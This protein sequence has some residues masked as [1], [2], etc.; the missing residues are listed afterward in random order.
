M[1]V[2]AGPYTLAAGRTVEV[3]PGFAQH[4]R[5]KAIVLTNLSGFVCAVTLQ[6]G[7]GVWLKPWSIHAY[8]LTDTE[9]DIKVTPE[10]PVAPAT[11]SG[12]L[13]ADW[14]ELDDPDPSTE[15]IGLFPP[16]VS[17]FDPYPAFSA[18]TVNAPTL[19][20]AAMLPAPPAG[21]NWRLRRI[22]LTAGTTAYAAA[23]SVYVVGTTSGG[24]VIGCFSSA[25]GIENQGTMDLL[26]NEGLTLHNGTPVT[27]ICTI[28]YRAEPAPD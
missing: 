26:I 18:A 15:T 21:Y 14:L 23:Q 9:A 28:W 17:D 24:W 4:Q 19:T 6:T 8:D 7:P 27:A 22:A 16:G 25:T 13:T 5:F 2:P 12:T 20:L 11:A 3:L 1:A 10:V